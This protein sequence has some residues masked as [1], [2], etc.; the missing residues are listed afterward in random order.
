MLE[1][2]F[3]VTKL[4]NEERQ[5]LASFI[6]G[7]PERIEHA[8]LHSEQTVDTPY[9]GERVADNPFASEAPPL[10]AGATAA[11][12]SAGV[13]VFVTAPVEVQVTTSSG[14]AIPASVPPVPSSAK[15]A[16]TVAPPQTSHVELDSEG[17][18]WDSR[19][20]SSSRGKIANGTWKLMRG[21]DPARVEAVK[22]ELRALMSA[23]VNTSTPFKG[24]SLTEDGIIIHNPPN[25]PVNITNPKSHYLIDQP[26]A[27]IKSIEDLQ[28]VTPTPPPMATVTY[29]DEKPLTVTVT[30]TGYVPLPAVSSIRHG[31]VDF[32]EDITQRLVSKKLTQSDILKAC[33]DAGIAAPNLLATRPDLIPQ[34]ARA[35]DV[36]V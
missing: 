12:I 34:V 35:L 18:P 31:F 17:L 2:K 19:I 4:N 28:S 15:V 33:T 8:T 1:I 16:E 27:V 29:A 14:Q 21:S 6:L 5:D 13:E 3:D 10:P 25:P 30:P 9:Q 20:H 22:G 11:P 26:G 7:W 23:P 24:M 36:I 32:I